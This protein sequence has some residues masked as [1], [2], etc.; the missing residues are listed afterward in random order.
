MDE[1][2]R[3]WTPLQWPCKGN[4]CSM[5]K[6]TNEKRRQHTS[7]CCLPLATISRMNGETEMAKNREANFSDAL[8]WVSW[9]KITARAETRLRLQK[10]RVPYSGDAGAQPAEEGSEPIG[11]NS[12]S[13]LGSHSNGTQVAIKPDWQF[14]N[15]MLEMEILQRT[16]VKVPVNYS[17]MVSLEC[18][19]NSN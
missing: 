9:P 8:G 4:D 11:R 5:L 6:A 16:I 17:Y 14:I 13:L 18:V 3:R 1:D 19:D 7:Y 15:M 10:N 12:N 2:R